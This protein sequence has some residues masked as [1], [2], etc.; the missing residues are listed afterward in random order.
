[1]SMSMSMPTHIVYALLTGVCV[2]APALEEALRRVRQQD[3]RILGRRQQVAGRPRAAGD[4]RAAR[5]G[6]Q[7]RLGGRAAGRAHGLD[8]RVAVVGEHAAAVSELLAVER[9]LEAH[10]LLGPSQTPLRASLGAL[11]AAAARGEPVRVTWLPYSWVCHPLR[12]LVDDGDEE[13]GDDDD[14]GET[15]AMRGADVHLVS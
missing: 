12:R 5:H 15:I 9:N 3:A 14:E 4:G 8:D 10:R 6:E 13:G 11:L 7:L 2:C 1:M